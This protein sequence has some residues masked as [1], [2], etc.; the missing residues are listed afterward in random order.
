ME[1]FVIIKRLMQQGPKPSIGS[2]VVKKITRHKNDGTDIGFDEADEILHRPHGPPAG[3][4][5]FSPGGFF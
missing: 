4:G 3:G 1:L 2:V 5:Y